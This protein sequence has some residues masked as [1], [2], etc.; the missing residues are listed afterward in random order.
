MGSLKSYNIFIESEVN[1]TINTT[2]NTTK[3]TRNLNQDSDQQLINKLSKE[4]FSENHNEI[5]NIL[6]KRFEDA[7][8]V[9]KKVKADNIKNALNFYYKQHN[10]EQSKLPEQ[11]KLNQNTKTDQNTDIKFK[12]SMVVVNNAINDYKKLSF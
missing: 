4:E 10:Q 2:I 6:K 1:T 3:K 12:Q 5:I 8:R 9:N 11:K 7:K